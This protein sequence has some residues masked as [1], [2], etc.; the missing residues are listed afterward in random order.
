MRIGARDRNRSVITSL[1]QKTNTPQSDDRDETHDNGTMHCT[2]YIQ[3]VQCRQP[4]RNRQKRQHRPARSRRVFSFVV[5]VVALHQL[6]AVGGFFWGSEGYPGSPQT[7]NLSTISPP[8]EGQSLDVVE[9]GFDWLPPRFY[10]GRATRTRG[11]CISVVWWCGRDGVD[12]ETSQKTA[13]SYV[14]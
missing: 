12:D 4:W 3:N 5:V 14:Q 8:R 6:G 1:V 7:T 13:R 11:R 2:M 9:S 10:S